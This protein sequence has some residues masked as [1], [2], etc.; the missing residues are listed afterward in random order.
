M[1]KFVIFIRL[2]NGK[3]LPLKVD[4]YDKISIIK[5]R[6]AEEEGTEVENQKL[7][8]FYKELL[9]DKLLSDY[10]YFI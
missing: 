4:Q 3:S 8:Y 7:T 9:D 1:R 5:A 6:L 2:P 10:N